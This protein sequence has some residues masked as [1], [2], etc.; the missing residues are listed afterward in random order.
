MQNINQHQESELAQS[1]HQVLAPWLQHFVDTY[2]QL[3]KDNLDLLKQLYHPDI[4]FIDP[5]HKLQGIENLQPYFQALYSNILTCQFEI[6][7]VIQQGHQAAIYWDMTYQHPK[8]NKGQVITVSGHSHI[9]ASG[10]QIIYHRD[11]LD[12]GEMLYEHLPV[13]GKII[14]WIKAKAGR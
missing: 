13:I 8:L 12:I 14:C 9:K 4:V 5:M 6:Q 3:S 10:E 11:Y 1:S 7:Q 2:Q